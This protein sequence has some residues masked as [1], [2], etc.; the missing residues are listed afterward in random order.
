MTAV[1]SCHILPASS[2]DPDPGTNR[3]F[4]WKVELIGPT[5]QTAGT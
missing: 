3:F 4:R 2:G 1:S 5:L